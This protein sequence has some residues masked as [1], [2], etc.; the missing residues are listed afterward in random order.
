MAGTVLIWLISGALGGLLAGR[1]LRMGG[2]AL[3]GDMLLGVLAGAL[4][5]LI[6]VAFES[7]VSPSVLLA[8]V[9]VAFLAGLLQILMLSLL[10]DEWHPARQ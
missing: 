9:A 3:I 1:I 7:I 10:R 2:Y 6:V 5:G 4:G 8:S